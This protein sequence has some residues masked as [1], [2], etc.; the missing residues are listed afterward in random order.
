M[1]E[2]VKNTES[3]GISR[4]EFARNAAIAAATVAVVPTQ[5][6]AQTE[7]SATPIKPPVA[8]E[9]QALSVAAKSEAEATYQFV[10]KKYG[11][12]LDPEQRKDVHR[13]ILQQQK[14]I[15]TIRAFPLNN[16][17]GP[18]MVLHVDVSEGR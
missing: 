5:I 3:K 4:R 15:E 14:S 6:L 11:E 13:L 16:G 2:D 10:L 1:I 17:D 9:E 8:P 18:A 7:K 12:R